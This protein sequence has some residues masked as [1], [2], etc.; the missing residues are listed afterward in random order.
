VE[1]DLDDDDD[2]DDEIIDLDDDVPAETGKENEVDEQIRGDAFEKIA[3]YERYLD[4]PFTN[5]WHPELKAPLFDAQIIGFRWMCDRY[6]H[7][8]GLVAD[9]VGVGKV[10]IQPSFRW[11]LTVA[12][13]HIKLSTSC[14]GYEIDSQ[15][16]AQTERSVSL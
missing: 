10:S 4:L 6:N 2:D 3:Q 11:R 5:P 13:R 1:Q 12:F 8:G 14:Y 9:K 16:L 7:G 15:H